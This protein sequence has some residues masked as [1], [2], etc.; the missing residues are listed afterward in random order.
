MSTWRGSSTTRAA[1]GS[2][3]SSS[4]LN[5]SCGAVIVWTKRGLTGDLMD[6]HRRSARL[7]YARR[8]ER[9]SCCAIATVDAALRTSRTVRGVVIDPADRLLGSVTVIAPGFTSAITDDSGRFRLTLSRTDR[10]IFDV[11]RVGFMPSRVRP[12]R[13]RRH[14]HHDSPIARGR[15]RWARSMSRVRKLGP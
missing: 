1:I 14:E 11:R 10:V 2:R 5:G 3:R 12:R 8:D 9:R 7:A 15:K 4:L 13:R 6:R